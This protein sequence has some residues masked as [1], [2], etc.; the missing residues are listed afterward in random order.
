MG[1]FSNGT[2]GEMFEAR[3]CNRCAHE[4]PV[5]GCP[6]MLAHLLFAY[7]LCNEEKHPGKI[8]LDILIPLSEPLGNKDCEMFIDASRLVRK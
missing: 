3:Q 8:I 4:D 2:D 6:V 1:Y 5:K 7:E